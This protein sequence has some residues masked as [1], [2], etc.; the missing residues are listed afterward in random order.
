MKKGLLKSQAIIMVAT[1]ITQLFAKV[2]AEITTVGFEKQK[3]EQKRGGYFEVLTL[4]PPQFSAKLR[5]HGQKIL[6]STS[7]PAAAAESSI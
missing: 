5:Q 3:S 7:T 2:K 1:K 4:R 6:R